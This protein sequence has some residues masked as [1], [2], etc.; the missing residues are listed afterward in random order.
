MEFTAPI[1]DATT[2]VFVDLDFLDCFGLLLDFGA[3]GALGSLL[4]F[5]QRSAVFGAF[6]ALGAFGSLG[7]SGAFVALGAFDSLGAS[8][9]F[10]ALGALVVVSGL[11]AALGS[12]LLFRLRCSRR[13]SLFAEAHAAALRNARRTTFLECIFL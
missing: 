3:L 4:L 13:K 6:V 1:A 2:L 8:G 12:L 11:L 7:A 5:N 10:V 9:A